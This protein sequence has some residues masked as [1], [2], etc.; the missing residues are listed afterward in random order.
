MSGSGPASEEGGATSRSA[1]FGL[2]A[3]GA[4]TVVLGAYANHFDNSFHFDDS[5][6][7]EDNVFI[8]SLSNAPRFFT[9][10][11][12]FSTLPDHY[13]YRPLLTLTYALDY[14]I[15]GGLDPTPFHTT[16]LLMHLLVGAGLFLLFWR[17]ADTA[18]PGPAN[19]YLALFAA[20]WY[21]V[22]TANTE[23]VNYLS[24]RSDIAST[25]GIVGSFVV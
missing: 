18:D 23:T 6:V 11:S 12:T 19:R 3:V 9:D 21:C 7:I 2:A 13:V 5:H 1:V 8:R 24:S 10:A 4:L 20:L 16:Q 17:V 15:A 25:L 22:H 14:K